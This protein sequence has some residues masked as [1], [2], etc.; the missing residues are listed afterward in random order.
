MDTYLTNKIISS[1][2][3]HVLQPPL[4]MLWPKFPCPNTVFLFFEN[5]SMIFGILNDENTLFQKVLKNGPVLEK[6]LLYFFPLLGRGWDQDQ[7][8]KILF[9]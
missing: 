6:K 1:P 9:F 2:N 3:L 8:W 7:K 4:H 5:F